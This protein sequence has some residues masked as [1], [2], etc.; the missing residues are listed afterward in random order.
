MQTSRGPVT[1]F[2]CV[3]LGF[4]FASSLRPHL[5]QGSS[6]L[7]EVVRAQPHPLVTVIAVLKVKVLKMD[8]SYWLLKKKRQL[9]LSEV[10]GDNEA[11]AHWQQRTPSLQ[12]A[13]LS[14]SC[15]HLPI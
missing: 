13:S 3:S 6:T 11:V 12:A 8:C 9:K 14:P 15:L 5:R 2:D 10:I 1:L 4:L 7:T